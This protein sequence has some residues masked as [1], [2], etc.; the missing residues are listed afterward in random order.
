[1]RATPPSKPRRAGS[2][3]VD[4]RDCA[5]SPPIVV[6]I[7]EAASRRLEIKPS[8]IRSAGVDEINA[9]AQRRKA[10]EAGPILLIKT[11]AAAGLPDKH[12]S[13]A[14]LRL[15]VFALKTDLIL[16]TKKPMKTILKKCDE[17]RVAP[18]SLRFDATRSDRNDGSTLNPH[19]PQPSTLNPHRAFTIVEM[20]VVIAIISILAALLL[21]ALARAKITAQ[22][23][24]AAMEISQIVGAIQQY[25]SVYGR[26]PVSSQAQSAAAALAPPGDFT[27][28]GSFSNSVHALMEVY[29]GVYKTNNNEV[30]AILLDVTNIAVTSVNMNHQKNP[31][32]TIFLIAK[33]TDDPTMPGVGPDL[34]YRDPWGNPYVIT[35]DLSYD[36]QCQ[37][38]FYQLRAVS[39]SQP[40]SPTGINGLV[41]MTDDKGDG[42]NFRYRGKVMV[43]SAGP[44]KM[45]DTGS[46]ANAGVN[47]DNILSWQ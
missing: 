30:M 45:I 27:Y 34:V 21:P 46:P 26:F 28:G 43:W 24:Q 17:W 33:M 2:I 37:D 3:A 8:S 35:M 7:P 31:Q 9:K 47:K 20:L 38:V 10:D 25:D 11:V 22:K 13:P 42:D 19:N 36:E 39:Q 16:V 32:Q 40:D 23:R 6:R 4:W 1:M 41:N 29:T 18:S 15:C 12:S 14:S 5:W 44:D